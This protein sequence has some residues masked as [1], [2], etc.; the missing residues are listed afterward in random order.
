VAQS[1]DHDLEFS[2]GIAPVLIENE[3]DGSLLVLVPGGKFL[4]GRARRG[5]EVDLP[6][7]YMGIHPVTNA[8]YKRFVDATGHRP[9]DE[10]NWGKPVWQGKS[11]PAEKADHPVVCV[12]WDDAKAY[13]QWAGGRLPSELEWEKA[14]RGTDDDDYPWGHEHWGRAGYE[15][16]PWEERWDLNHCRNWKNRE[17]EETCGVWKY[18]QGCS[19]Y[20]L[21]QMAGNVWEWCEDWYD[22]DAYSR[23]EQRDLRPPDS[24]SLRVVRGGSWH[25]NFPDGF[26]CEDRYYNDPTARSHDG[27]FRLAKTLTA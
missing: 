15:W 13:C 4:A 6:G 16:E 26:R 27:G 17:S 18:P 3:K 2:T 24:G 1:S 14:S 20:G 22:T 19:P 5:F 23:Y 9:P 11:F 8:Q 7:F 21:Y 25:H 12:S 10:A